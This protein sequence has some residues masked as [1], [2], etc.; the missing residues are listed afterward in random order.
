MTVTINLAPEIEAEAFTQAK[1]AGVALE[2]YL[3]RLIQRAL[4][5]GRPPLRQGSREW[6]DLLQQ[7]PP[8]AR[9]DPATGQPPAA[10]TREAL[11]RENFYEDRA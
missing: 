7:A 3:P 8:V 5:L 11:R 10:T 6:L 9:I 1:A 2:D 4:P